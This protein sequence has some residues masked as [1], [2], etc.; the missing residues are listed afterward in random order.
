MHKFRPIA[1]ALVIGITSLSVVGI[2]DAAPAKKTSKARCHAVVNGKKTWSVEFCP[3]PAKSGVNGKD[4]INGANGANG[5]DG[6]NGVGVI[7]KNGANGNDGTNGSNGLN[8]VSGYEVRTFD[9]FKGDDYPG[10]GGGGVATVAC[11]SE[12][13]V[14]LSGGFWVRDRAD[15][16]KDANSI[17]SLTNGTGILASFPGRMD[18]STNRPKANRNDGWIIRFNS[19]TAS[20]DV[21]LYAVCVN[22][23]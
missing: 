15:A 18:W 11:S 13:K 23:A 14:A 16:K 17:P 6:S 7:G 1:A 2:A 12:N 21:T 4:G 19:N 20:A 10:V 9:Y 22:A 3:K 5:K 8:G